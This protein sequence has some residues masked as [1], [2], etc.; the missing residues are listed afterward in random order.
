MVEEEN[1]SDMSLMTITTIGRNLQKPKVDSKSVQIKNLKQLSEFATVQSKPVKTE[2][3]VI[4]MLD[5]YYKGI[6]TAEP[7]TNDD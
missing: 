3:E 5:T 6:S 4:Q 2:A 1:K 7:V